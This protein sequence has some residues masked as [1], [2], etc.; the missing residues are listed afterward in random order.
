MALIFV[1][2]SLRKDMYNYD[3]FLKDYDSYRYDA[4]VKGQL[5]SLKEVT[6]PALIDG[7]EMILGEIHEVPEQVLVLLDELESYIDENH[8]D[9]EYDKVITP[10]YNKNKEK[11]MELPIYKYNI[12]NQKNKALLDKI[13]ASNDYVQHMKKSRD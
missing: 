13:I 6:Y 3:K 2:G 12:R 1:Y 8:I 11:I 5:Y 4:Y 9:N 7:E 10:I